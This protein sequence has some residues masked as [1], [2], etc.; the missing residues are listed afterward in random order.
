[1]MRCADVPCR[2]SSPHALEGSVPPGGVHLARHSLCD[3]GFGAVLAYDCDGALQTPGLPAH[4]T[5]IVQAQ[6]LILQD[7]SLPPVV[8][9]GPHAAVHTAALVFKASLIFAFTLFPSSYHSHVCPVRGPR[10]DSNV[11][12]RR[13]CLLAF[14]CCAVS[15]L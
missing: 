1:M 5:G 8:L 7:D 11:S 6:Y 3:A 15:W 13:I 14:T 12:F 10:I 4:T 2:R 9:G